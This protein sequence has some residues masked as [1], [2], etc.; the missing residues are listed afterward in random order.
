MPQCHTGDRSSAQIQQCQQD[1]SYSWPRYAQ[2]SFGKCG[3][4]LGG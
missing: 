2:I 1:S 3:L 4:S